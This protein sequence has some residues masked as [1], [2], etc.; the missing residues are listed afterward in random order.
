[1]DDI[2]KINDQSDLMQRANFYK[3]RRPTEDA[4]ATG[5]C[6][7]CEA[8]LQPGMRWCGPE[9]RDDWEKLNNK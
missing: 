5:E 8:H 3:S 4:P 9:C 6:L 2:D 7:F 1:M